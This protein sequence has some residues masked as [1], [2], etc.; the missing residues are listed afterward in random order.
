MRIAVDLLDTAFEALD[1]KTSDEAVAS[2]SLA[3][4]ANLYGLQRLYF[5]TVPES[6]G[7]GRVEFLYR[8]AKFGVRSF[9]RTPQALVQESTPL[10]LF[11]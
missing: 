3:A 6:A 8:L 9:E 7:N 11:S 4:T 2:P 5:G 1:A 10:L